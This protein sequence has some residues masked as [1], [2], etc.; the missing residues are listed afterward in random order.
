MSGL[1]FKKKSTLAVWERIVRS[2]SLIGVRGGALLEE[3]DLGDYQILGALPS[4]IF[5]FLLHYFSILALGVENG[6]KRFRWEIRHTELAAH[7][8]HHQHF[9]SPG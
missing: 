8:H 6:G 7:H 3:M 2:I 1:I 5:F 4:L 9:I